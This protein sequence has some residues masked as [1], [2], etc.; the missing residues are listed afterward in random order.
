MTCRTLHLQLQVN[1]RVGT[2]VVGMP[3]RAQ[4][5][6]LA[7]IATGQHRIFGK[8]YKRLPCVMQHLEFRVESKRAGAGAHN[9]Y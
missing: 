9:A 6:F 2:T 3:V 7:S 8:E 5:F 4:A 1:G